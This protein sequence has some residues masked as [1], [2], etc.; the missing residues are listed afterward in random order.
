MPPFP[1]HHKLRLLARGASS[2]SYRRLDVLVHAE[3]IARIVLVLERD[4]TI[5]VAAISDP[6]PLLAL[7]AQLVDVEPRR[8]EWSQPFP[9]TVHPIYRGLA[10]RV[11]PP[12]RLRP[13][14]VTG[15]P[16]IE[17]HFAGS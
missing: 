10:R 8:K 17:G 2:A 15:L 14:V 11:V 12:E 7:V 4:K 5:I 1:H 13:E 6:H 3:K 9:R 16:E